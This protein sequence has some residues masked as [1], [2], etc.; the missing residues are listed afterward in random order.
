MLIFT[1]S[2]RE[3]AKQDFDELAELVV[4]PEGESPTPDNQDPLVSEEDATS[5]PSN[6]AKPSSPPITRNISLLKEMNSEC[7]GWIYIK[8]T[9][10]NYPVMHSPSNPEKYLKKNFYGQY[11]GSGVP[12]IDARCDLKS[13]NIIIYGHNMK[14]LTMFGG[15]RKY[16]DKSYLNS[17]PIIEFETSEGL[18]YYKITQVKK[19]TIKD[20]WFTHN[21]YAKQ[22]GKEYLTLSTCTGTN[23]NARLLVIAE[24]ITEK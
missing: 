12:F 9:K 14:N 6:T 15:L 22:D 7:V 21:L 20:T 3:K 18:S 1:V 10:V 17:H 16:L 5:K 23:K 2:D 13:T 19:T 11:S 4:L 24:K 8:G